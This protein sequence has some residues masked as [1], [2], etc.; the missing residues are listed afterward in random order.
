V[1]EAVTERE[2]LNCHGTF[3]E[4]PRANSGGYRKMRALATH[5]KRITDFASWR[6]LLVLTGVLDDAPATDRLVRNADG[7]AALWLGE[8]DDLWRMGEPRGTGGPWQD[9]AV[10]ANTPSDPYLMYGYGHKELAL[11]SNNAAT[12]TVEVDFLADNTWSIY[13]TF[14][15][16]AGESLTHVFPPGFHAHWVRVKSDAS[17]TAS[18]LFTYGPAEVRDRFLDWAREQELPTGSGRSALINQDDDG[19]GIPLLIEF[20]VNGNTSLFDPQPISA[21][22]N[23]AE[24]IL[25]DLLPTDGIAFSVQFTDNLTN[26]ESHPEYLAASPDQ[27]GV[28]AGFTRM[29]VTYPADEDHLFFRLRAE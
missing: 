13:Q 21:G 14:S 17:T 16:A 1:R 9:T 18:A 19:D 2:L 4:V 8:I 24:F 26:W 27:S 10:T 7:S 25:R 11:T 23:Q 22:E 29:R 3:Y 15:L 5:G 28:A 12:I 6:G 20:L